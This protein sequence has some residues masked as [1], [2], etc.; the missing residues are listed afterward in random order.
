MEDEIKAEDK[1][2]SLIAN[3]QTDLVAAI[4]RRIKDLRVAKGFSQAKL[5]KDLGLSRAAVTQWETGQ[6]T[7]NYAQALKLE[8]LLD[9]DVCYL[10]FGRYRDALEETDAGLDDVDD[11]DR[12]VQAAA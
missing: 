8:E 6:A 9:T 12:Q 1:I 10:I 7:C 4:G 5:A 2:K 3:L 11:V